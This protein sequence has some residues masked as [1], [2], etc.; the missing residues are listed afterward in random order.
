M[1][2]R[3]VIVITPIINPSS[4]ERWAS[5]SNSFAV[6]P[7]GNPDPLAMEHNPPWGIL[8][9]NNHYLVDLNRESFWAT[10]RESA[11]LR[12]FYYE[13]NPMVFIDH[14]GE[15]DNFVGP[16]YQQPL[17]PFYTDAQRRW[18]D[19]FG[20]AIDKKFTRFEW[21]YSP[22]ETGSFYPGFWES[23]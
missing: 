15:Y 18:L 14:H 4:H 11:A 21:S 7:A 8:T 1:E 3:A 2:T 13:W 9:N 10:Q 12:S 17:N 6:G 20:K 19:R 5:W 22:W 16:G 23:L